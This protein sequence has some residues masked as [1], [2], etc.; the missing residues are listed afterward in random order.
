MRE[1]APRRPSAALVI[2]CIALFV[3]LGGGAYAAL[4]K[5]SVSSKQI[6]NGSVKGKDLKNDTV[7]GKQVKEEKLGQ[8]P[9]AASADKAAAA[10]TATAADSVGGMKVIHVA[11]FT[12]TTGGSRQILQAGAFTLTATCSI[13]EGGTDFARV[14]ISTSVN[15]AAYDGDGSETNLDTNTPAANREYMVASATT[16]NPGIDQES[17]G[18][19]WAPDGSEIMGNDAFGAVNLP[20]DGLGTCRFGGAFYVN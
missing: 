3:A 20:A 5:N 16:G 12:L 14:L 17:D 11:P 9:S 10:D 15:D 7:T 8:V 4:S 13:N 2:A 1:H 18:A 19:A 6:K